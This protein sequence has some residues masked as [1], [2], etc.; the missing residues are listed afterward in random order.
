MKII[1]APDKFKG[2]LTS[3]EACM[4]I[5]EGILEFD[6]NNEVSIFPM[7]DGGDGFAEVMKY[8][9][10]TIS[11]PVQSVDAL[12]RK[13]STTYE[14][15]ADDR[16]AIIE[17]ASCSGLAMLKKEE[18][19]PLIT[20]TYGTGLQI[21]HSI[22]KG[23][24]KIII[25]LGGSSTNDAGI[26][27]L[28]ALGFK[29]YDF[30]N[31]MLQPCGKNLVHIHTISSPSSIPTVLFEI[32]CDV[33]NPL[34]GPDGAA[35]IFSPQKGANPDQVQLLD[36]G[37]KQF[38]RVVKQHTRRDVSTFPGAG[39]AGGIAAGLKAYLN[40][41]L[42]EGTAMIIRASRIANAIKGVEIIITGEGKLD[43][44]SMRGKTID[45]I[46]SLARENNI[47]VVGLCGK[48]DLAEQEWKKMGLSLADAIN[49][50]SVSEEDSMKNASLL[51]K[52]KTKS[53]MP[54]LKDLVSHGNN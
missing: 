8:Y 38:A 42:V 18:R 51:L 1:I 48:L 3:L 26:G 40:V 17:L 53:I 23:A 29:F 45:A 15:K 46:T 5:K 25:G 16:V 44:Q 20:S 12:G 11:Q 9:T 2:S 7:A 41:E 21:K 32:A 35:H 4:A 6:S 31:H 14:W 28:C 54:L 22:E 10:G 50:G 19:N 27:I 52:E 47:R 34:H 39:A 36:E 13:I 33:N 43:Q 49:D 24:S 30:S 37:L